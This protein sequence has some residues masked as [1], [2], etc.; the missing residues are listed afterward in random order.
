MV[1]KEK[2]DTEV[3]FGGAS[4]RQELF[5]DLYAALSRLQTPGGF[6]EPLLIRPA[7][8]PSAPQHRHHPCPQHLH[9]FAHRCLA[10]EEQS[11]FE[12]PPVS[13]C[14]LPIMFSSIINHSQSVALFQLHRSGLA[15]TM[16]L[17]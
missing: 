17:V 9:L 5:L 11:P 16:Q 13:F 3:D 10:L 2:T 4:R 8:R 14:S 12:R 6:R 1:A 15:V 7:D